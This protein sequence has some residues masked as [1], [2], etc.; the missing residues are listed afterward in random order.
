MRLAAEL[1]ELVVPSVCA[2]CDG[3]RRPGDPLLCSRCAAGLR[4]LHALGEVATALA[5]TGTGRELVHRFKFDAR[6]DAL[7]ILLEPLVRRAAGLAADV[8]VP[9]PSHRA[10]VGERGR[11]PVWQ[12]ARALGRRAR[13]PVWDRPLARTRPTAPQTGLGIAE[14]RANVAGTFRAAA[15]A[16][17]GRRVLL[18]DDVTTTGTTLAEAAH[19]LRRH[20]DARHIVT[21]ALAGTP[22]SA[23][24]GT[25]VRTA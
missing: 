10:R 20:S 23:A 22:P 13:L 1:L 11:D 21:L 18:L 7:A 9:L 25:T 24:S 8:I 14:R 3:P 15:G 16:L 2:A 4:P 17:R 12:L 19:A 5:Y 6:R